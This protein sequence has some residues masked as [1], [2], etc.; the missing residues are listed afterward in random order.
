MMERREFYDAVE[1]WGGAMTFGSVA[2]WDGLTETLAEMSAEQK[3]MFSGYLNAIPYKAF[4]LT[5]YWHAIKL[6]M[7]FDHR[8]CQV[9]RRQ[10]KVE[11]HHRTYEHR[12][13]EF[14]HLADLR[15]LCGQC[16]ALVHEAVMFVKGAA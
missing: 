6:K 1:F 16:H 2:G 13:S 8:G 12:G 7:Q 9:C 10:Q 11:V 4:L 14:A 3:G 15:L 5:R